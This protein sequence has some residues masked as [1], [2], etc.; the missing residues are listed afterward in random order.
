[1]EGRGDQAGGVYGISSGY[2]RAMGTPLLAGRDLTDDEGFAAA[3]VGV[4]NETAARVLCGGAAVCVG[5]VVHAPGQ[6]PR[7]IVGIVRD[8]RQSMQRQPMAAMYVPFDPAR[9]VVGSIVIDSTDT[10]ESRAGLIR[11]LYS[12]PSVR[13]DVRS[14]D[15]ARDGE[16]SPFRFNAIL[17]SSFAGLTLALAV[18][19][20][21]G[22]MTAVVGERTREYGIRLAL[23]ATRG[24]VNRHVVAQASMPI[25]AG[26]AGGLVLAVWGS[27][28]VASVLY[29]IVPLD[30]PSFVAAAGIV[31]VS[32]LVAALIPARRAGRVDP[33]VALRAE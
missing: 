25:A 18:V 1:M 2:F 14:L 6:A 28:Y 32:G 16:L 20:V 13:V 9:F 11:P 31:L 19:G 21:Y 8:M 29:G 22:V 12:S 26:I 3:P 4:L 24:R 17:V 7:T 5:R 15:E 10:A 30:A 33:I 23:G 27:R